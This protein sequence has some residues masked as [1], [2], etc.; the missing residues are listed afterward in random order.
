MS[1]GDHCL[2][3]SAATRL[4]V[5]LAALFLVLPVATPSLAIAGPAILLE[6]YAG[7]RPEEAAPYL[8]QLLAALAGK[9][10]LNGAPLRELIESRLSRD[11]GSGLAAAR[12]RTAVEEGGRLFIEGEFAAAIKQLEKA[13]VELQKE[14]FTL[15]SDQSLRDALHRALLFLAHAYLRT[16]QGE[17]AIERIG[18]VIRS[19]P[20]RDLSV[21]QVQYGPELVSLYRQVRGELDRQG[22]G[23]LVVNT[24][25][26]GCLVFVDERFVGVSPAR[27]V[28][29]YPGRYRVYVQR[30]QRP[31]RVHE[32]TLRGGEQ[33]V[34]IRF[35]L[36][37][38]LHSG[39]FVGFRFADLDSLERQ[40]IPLATE[41]GQ[42]LDASSV[43]LVGFRQH[44]GR[45]ALV[46]T[47]ISPVAGRLRTAMVM[48][49]PT[50][51]SPETIK[52]LGRFLI[53]GQEAA[54]L[55]VAGL[56]GRPAPR[57]ARSGGLFS[58]RVFKWVTL[59]ISAGALAGGVTLLVL[60]GRGT[61]DS[62]PGA[63]CPDIYDTRL[64]GAVLT[65]AGGL[66]GAASALL[67]YWD[68]R[69]RPSRAESR[70]AA[71]LPWLSGRAAGVAAVVSY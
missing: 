68:H 31:G 61:C 25:P 59:G 51:P 45:K 49:E 21:V 7:D 12:M 5:P 62:A 64:A 70:A 39:P 57:P 11:A 48:V 18:E 10:P 26:P 32:V 43:L 38:A 53:D 42:A 13:R 36:D 14:V 8:G 58:A 20:D 1:S 33:A 69:R 6:S 27:V 54:G 16:R 46:G 37:S 44:Q 29:L 15:A 35:D 63:R 50:P 2:A 71:L 34:Q 30:Q 23:T 40:E 65:G 47:A 24:Q 22:R 17:R 19:F 66:A 41:V 9:A 55:I 56:G 28:D 52:A 60:H 3:R 67:F 4:I